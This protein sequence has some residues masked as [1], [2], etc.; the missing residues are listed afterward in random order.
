M[1]VQLS[2]VFK[3]ETKGRKKNGL[4]KRETERKIREKI[5][6]NTEKKKIFKIE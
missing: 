2:F 3:M 6:E 4:E 1:C 5:M